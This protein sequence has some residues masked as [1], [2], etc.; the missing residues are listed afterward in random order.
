MSLSKADL[1][2]SKALSGFP[3]EGCLFQGSGGLL[4]GLGCQ[5]TWALGSRRSLVV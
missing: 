5:P 2:D 1:P 4:D 3:G